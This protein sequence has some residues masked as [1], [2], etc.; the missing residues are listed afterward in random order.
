MLFWVTVLVSILSVCLAVCVSV[1]NIVG[2]NGNP[3]LDDKKTGMPRACT[4]TDIWMSIMITF[5]FSIRCAGLHELCFLPEWHVE[6][7]GHG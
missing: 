6:E 5:L 3:L 4:D 1:C 2:Y 7:K